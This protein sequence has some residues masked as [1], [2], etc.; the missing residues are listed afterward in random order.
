MHFFVWMCYIEFTWSG[1]DWRNTLFSSSLLIFSHSRLFQSCYRF[2]LCLASV[3]RLLSLIQ[4]FLV[5]S[6][7]QSLS[8]RS[9]STPWRAASPRRQHGTEPPWI[10]VI[11]STLNVH[12]TSRLVVSSTQNTPN[13][14]ARG[15]D[16]FLSL[17][18]RSS[19][20][21]TGTSKSTGLKTCGRGTWPGKG[22]RRHRAVLREQ[23]TPYILTPTPTIHLYSSCEAA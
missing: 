23:S 20:S 6:Y 8:L 7:F 19:L 3:T 1:E 14:T 16:P 17:A 13:S 4:V 5:S 2:D 10:L 21:T 22:M 12:T 11:S 9:P 15:L 18:K